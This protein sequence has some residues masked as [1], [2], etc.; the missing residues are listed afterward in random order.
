[1]FA[2]TIV[3]YEEY[4]VDCE[5]AP[6]IVT[7]REAVLILQELFHNFVVVTKQEV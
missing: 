2:I 1:M 5:K 4:L 7:V 6:L 3:I